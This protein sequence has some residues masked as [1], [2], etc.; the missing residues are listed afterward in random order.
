[1]GKVEIL[2]V[3]PA[4]GGSKGIRRK[5]IRLLNGKPLIYYQIKNALSS[6]YITDVVVTSEDEDILSYVT[7]FEKVY[8]RTRPKDLAGDDVTL[9]PVVY[10]AVIYMEKT[11][12]KRYDLVITLQPTSPLLKVST[13]DTAI[14][15]VITKGWDTLIPVVEATHLYWT[16]NK[17]RIHPDYS[18]R[19][20]R[21]WLPRRYKETGAFLITR[22]EFI[23]YNSRFGRNIGIFIMDDEEGIDIDTPLDWLTAET[24]LRRLKI[25]FVVNGN[26][27]IGMGH[28]YRT[29]TLADHM[30]GHKI[31]FLTYNSEDNAIQ[32]IK[33][34]GYEVIQ[35]TYEELFQVIKQLH[36][37]KIINDIL[38]TSPEYVGQ[39][40]DL[41]VFVVN[42]EDLGDGA[43]K[44]HIVF[45]ALYEKTN[46]SP[47]HRFGHM[48]ECLNEKFYL[49]PPIEFRDPPRTLFI[50]FGGVDQNN[51]TAKVLQLAPSLLKETPLE[52]ILVVIGPGYKHTQQ[53]KSIWGNLG[54]LKDSVEIHFKVKNMPRLMKE[55]DIAITS[56]GRTIYELTAMGIPTISISQNDRE[57]LHLF[58][59][60]HRGIEYLGIACTVGENDIM[61]AIKEIALNKEKRRVMYEAQIEAGKTIRKGARRVIDEIF[62]EYW[63]WKDETNQDWTF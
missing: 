4:R 8:I 58:A 35:T 49:Y 14:R 60:Y 43:D 30:I 1:V 39:L 54:E 28:V 12:N 40:K 2:A 20:N 3:I 42:F 57:T 5:N 11:L 52:R 53:L 7:T 34:S 51:L 44:A 48:Y 18:E 23:Q 9:D 19:L 62:S 50:S 37:D 59:R 55:A 25:V 27:E 41:G 61:T 26:K 16:E 32:L 45:N 15:E 47:N 31:T 29:I 13:L 22:R 33:E 6:K 10:D 56:N 17:G 24:L 63:R 36:P 21:Q 46:P 38:D